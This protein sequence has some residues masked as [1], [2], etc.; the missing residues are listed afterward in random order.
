MRRPAAARSH[1][2]R[3]LNLPVRGIPRCAAAPAGLCPIVHTIAR[4]IAPPAHGDSRATAGDNRA[5]SGHRAARKRIGIVTLFNRVLIANRGEIACR[6]IRTCRR[7]GIE[8]VA[9]YSEAD[10]SAQHVR[11]A[12]VALPIGGPRPQDSYLRAEAIIERGATL[13]RAG[14][15]SGLRLSFRERRFRR[16]RR[17]RRHALHRSARRID[18]AHGIESRRE[19]PHG[20]PR[21]AGRAGL[22]GRRSGPIAA[23]ARSRARSVFR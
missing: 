21:R 11:L 14:D 5:S 9:V 8:T 10:A 13:R 20:K 12:D 16:S 6:V 2:P 3:A 1:P 22:H 7:L 4:D 18:A 19:G 23:R 17:A 15:P